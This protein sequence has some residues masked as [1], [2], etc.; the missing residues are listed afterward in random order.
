VHY[1]PRTGQYMAPDGHMYRQS[2]LAAAGP[3]KTWQELVLRQG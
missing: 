2:D 3:A 1:D